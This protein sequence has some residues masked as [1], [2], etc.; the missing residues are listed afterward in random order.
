M[1]YVRVQLQLFTIRDPLEVESAKD[2]RFVLIPI[3][4]L[5]MS[6]VGRAAVLTQMTSFTGC[7]TDTNHCD[8]DVTPTQRDEKESDC[9]EAKKCARV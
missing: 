4:K 5:K 9:A 7:H 6:G 2:R 3:E 8:E 1:L